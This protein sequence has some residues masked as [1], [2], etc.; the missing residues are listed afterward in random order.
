MEDPM[1]IDPSP[2]LRDFDLEVLIAYL[3]P[4]REPTTRDTYQTTPLGRG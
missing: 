3:P 4:V 1:E 2:Y